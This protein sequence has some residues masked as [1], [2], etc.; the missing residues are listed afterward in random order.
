MISAGKSALI[1]RYHSLC[2]TVRDVLDV[3]DGF[4]LAAVGLEIVVIEVRADIHSA[5]AQRQQRIVEIEQI[6]I[7]LIDQIARPVVEVLDIGDVGQRIERV[8][9][10]IEALRIQPLPPLVL[11]FGLGQAR[12]RTER[13]PVGRPC[14]RHAR[15]GT[16][17]SCAPDAP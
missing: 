5:P 17:T 7:V 4:H 14:P 15:A 10:A 8:L 12:H 1:V 11:A 2:Q 3:Q 16:T 6:G 9:H 13:P